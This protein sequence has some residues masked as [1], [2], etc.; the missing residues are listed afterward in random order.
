M[1]E[2]V[3]FEET[4]YTYGTTSVTLSEPYTNFEMLDIYT[5]KGDVQRFL[6]SNEHGDSLPTLQHSSK[7]FLW[8]IPWSFTNSVTL[9]GATGRLY[10]LGTT[11][12]YDVASNAQYNRWIQPV[13][14][15]G[16]N[17]I[18]GGN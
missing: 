8:L 9:T 10:E 15:V 11:N 3:L 17:R 13:K 4:N 6:T 16:I 7:N 12:K 2:T 14:I 5:S 18:S 1:D